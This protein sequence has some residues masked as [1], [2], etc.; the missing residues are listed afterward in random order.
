MSRTWLLRIAL[1]TADF[2]FIATYVLL[3][4]HAYDW[5]RELDPAIQQVPEDPLRD[6]RLLLTSL[7]LLFSA[8]LHGVRAVSVRG[9]RPRAVHATFIVLFVALWLWR[10]FLGA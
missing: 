2:V 1:L 10:N 5:M 6:T 4:R 3:P 8:L 7:L 9:F